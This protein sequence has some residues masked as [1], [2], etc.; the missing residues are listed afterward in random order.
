MTLTSVFVTLSSSTFNLFEA[1]DSLSME[2]KPLSETN[3]SL[4]SSSLL[5]W[6]IPFARMRSVPRNKELFMSVGVYSIRVDLS[7]LSCKISKTI[8]NA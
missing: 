8:K 3:D 1:G 6:K 2:A 7:G 4:P 5:Q